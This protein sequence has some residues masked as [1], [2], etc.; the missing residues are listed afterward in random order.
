LNETLL[1]L[2]YF[3]SGGFAFAGAYR[4]RWNIG[5]A[6]LS[7]GLIST[8]GWLLIFGLTDE[9]MRPRWIRLD[10]SLNLTLGLMFAAAGA[11]LGWWMLRPRPDQDR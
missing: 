6:V 7:G 5:L 4:W 2:V 8:I 1:W 3:V 9:E 10:L 11:L